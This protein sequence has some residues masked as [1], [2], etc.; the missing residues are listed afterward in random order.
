MTTSDHRAL[1]NNAAALAVVQLVNYVAPLLV[2]L[3]LTRVLGVALYGVVAFSIGVVSL[4][5]VL[6]DLGFMLSATER[7]ARRRHRRAYVERLAGAVLALKF[8]AAALI[9]LVF[10][11]FAVSSPDYEAHRGLLLLTVL[12]ILTQAL[13]PTWLFQG[14]ERMHWVTVVVVCSRLGFLAGVVGFVREPDAYEL[15]PLLNAGAQ[16]VALVAA[17]A[18]CR[19][20]GYRIRLPDVAYCR[21][22]LRMTLGFLGS[23]LAVATYMN[24]GTV[25]LGALGE[26]TAVAVYSVAEQGYRVLQNAVA[27]VVTAVYPY[28]ARVANLALL[29]KLTTATLAAA[30]V[31]AGA[32]H[33]LAPP[34]IDLLFGTQWR[35][36]TAVFDLFLLAFPIH[37]LTVFAG[38]PLAA[39]LGAVSIA[40]RS[41]VAGALVFP[42]AIAIASWL[43]TLDPQAVVLA[44]L[45][46][47]IAVLAL[48][49]RLLAPKLPRRSDQINGGSLLD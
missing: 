49:V 8:A 13:M 19:R 20:E 38:Y 24:S 29:A 27:P 16:S 18:L 28:L 12:P 5:F 2:M 4:S 1:R 22:A 10:A 39:A 40:N 25:L 9:S 17:F 32:S 43:G 15:V 30:V 26:T 41:V 6:A 23:R 42:I 44:M 14:I 31:V 45:A 21:H 36:A 34:A 48:R 7:I 47:E 46:A 37:V 35:P 11:L 3:Y 33:Y